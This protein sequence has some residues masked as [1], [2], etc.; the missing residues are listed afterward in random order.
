MG[1]LMIAV[2]IGWNEDLTGWDSLFMTPFV[3][4]SPSHV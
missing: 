2:E 3:L 1:L 4:L